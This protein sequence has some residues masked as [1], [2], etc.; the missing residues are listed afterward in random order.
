MPNIH[1]LDKLKGSIKARA[2]IKLERDLGPE[3]LATL[4]NREPSKLSWIR[5]ARA[6]TCL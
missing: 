1:Y 6:I 2:K 3:I 4:T 5:M